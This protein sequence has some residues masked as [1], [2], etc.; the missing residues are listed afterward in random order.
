[1]RNPR[2][3]H[4]EA[5][6]DDTEVALTPTAARHLGRALRLKAGDPCTLFDGSGSE[7][8]ATLL[9]GA[10]R[11]RIGRGIAPDRES[12]LALTLVQGISRGERMDWTIQKAVELGVVAIVPVFTERGGVKLTGDRLERRLEHWRGVIVA[13][14]EQCGRNRL[15]SIAAPARFAEWLPT[16]AGPAC[17]LDPAADAGLGGLGRPSPGLSLIAGPEGGLTDAELAAARVAGCVAVRI[18]PRVL[19]T[20][21]AGIAAISALQALYGDLS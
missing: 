12:P 11:A 6:T 15:P 18:G 19:R 13:A 14:C 17:V 5:L 3:F 4:P 2:I 1:M 8:P 9:D 10:T 20:E 21:T 16:L 7:W